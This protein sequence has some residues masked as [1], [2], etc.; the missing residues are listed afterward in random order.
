LF[1]GIRKP[2]RNS[3]ASF[4][5]LVQPSLLAL[6]FKLASEHPSFAA[7]SFNGSFA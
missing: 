5:V 1:S 2:R 3:A 7:M 4:G 6:T